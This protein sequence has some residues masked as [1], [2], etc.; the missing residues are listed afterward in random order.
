MAGL[1]K[2]W[3]MKTP[4]DSD[5]WLEN[6]PEFSRPIAAQ[7]REW[8]L[9]WEP[10]LRE[11]IKWG[12]LCFSG[13][14]LVLG[15]GAFKKHV[16]IVFFRGSELSDPTRLFEQ[17]GNVSLRTI[18]LTTLD[19]FNRQAFRALLR[20][21][22]ELDAEPAVP[23]PPGPKREPLPLPDFFAKALKKDKSA[24]AGFEKLSPSCQREYIAWLSSAKR[25]ETREKRLAETLSALADGRKWAQRK[26]AQA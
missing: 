1:V 2:D 10:D 3:R 11:A 8:I 16:G 26:P 21:A 17:E 23:K 15:L 4:R 24:S 18:R 14:K 22:V 7:L 19:G 5:D 12:Q 9:Q 20:A 6:A 25:P 13:H